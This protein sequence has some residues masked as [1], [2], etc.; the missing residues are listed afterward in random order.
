M[1]ELSFEQLKAITPFVGNANQ[2]V[3]FDARLKLFLPHL[4]EAFRM[5]G[6]NTKERVA[7]FLAQIIH[8]SGAFR[9]VKEIASGSAYEGRKDLGNTHPG[10]GVKFKG[11]GLIQITGRANYEQIS[12]AFQVDFVAKPEL[13]ESIEFATKSAAWW[14]NNRKL[15]RFA[16]LGQ[17]INCTKIINGGTN[18]LEDRKANYQRA[19]MVLGVKFI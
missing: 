8:E 19:C 9:Y 17:I 16:D 5:F 6:I 15:N 3:Q 10:D 13:L 7:M 14:W 1:F 12:K 2:R 18:G 11:R 4:N